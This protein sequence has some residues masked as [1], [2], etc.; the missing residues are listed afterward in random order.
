MI[1]SLQ[2]KSKQF[3]HCIFMTIT[4]VYIFLLHYKRKSQW[5]KRFLGMPKALLG[6]FRQQLNGNFFP[7]MLFSRSSFVS[8]LPFRH[9]LQTVTIWVC[10][11]NWLHVHLKTLFSSFYSR[12][13]SLY[14]AYIQSLKKKILSWKAFAV[15]SF[16]DLGFWNQMILNAAV[17]LAGDV[18]I[19]QTRIRSTVD[20]GVKPININ[21]FA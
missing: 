1:K 16:L 6:Y 12:K 14:K 4:Y 18:F 9:W 19:L 10:R 15:F 21:L 8:H 11:C 2:C 3:N 7:S 17:R 5:Q 20:P 13:N